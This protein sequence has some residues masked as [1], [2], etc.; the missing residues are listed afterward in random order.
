MSL[1]AYLAG[2]LSVADG[3]ILT[4]A[5]ISLLFY[6]VWLHRRIKVLENESRLVMSYLADNLYDE[7]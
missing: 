2:P 6:C 5:C 4:I 1:D 3:W 7:E